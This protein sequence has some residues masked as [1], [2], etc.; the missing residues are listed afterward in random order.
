MKTNLNELLEPKN[1]EAIKKSEDILKAGGKGLPPGAVVFEGKIMSRR[2]LLD[3]LVERASLTE[4]ERK[5]LEKEKEE[6][7]KRKLQQAKH[8]AQ[9]AIESLLKN[10]GI[11]KSVKELLQEKDSA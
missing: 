10:P 2:E 11:P 8:S 6:E 5:R 3:I 9:E 7:K 1:M 4:E